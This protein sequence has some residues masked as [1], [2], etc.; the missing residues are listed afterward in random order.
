MTNKEHILQLLAGADDGVLFDAYENLPD[1]MRNRQPIITA[2][3]SCPE[4]NADDCYAD[5][6]SCD[7]HTSAWMGAEVQFR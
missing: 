1:E 2:C 3:Q 7:K 5:Y 4:R 6:E